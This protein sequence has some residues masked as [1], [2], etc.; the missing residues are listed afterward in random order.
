LRAAQAADRPSSQIAD[1]MAKAIIN[2]AEADRQA[3]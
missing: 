2:N 3:A 1:E